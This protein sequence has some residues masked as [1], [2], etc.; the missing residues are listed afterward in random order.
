[1]ICTSP[2]LAAADTVASMFARPS[3]IIWT[4]RSPSPAP[5]QFPP[6]VPLP[7]SIDCWGTKKDVPNEKLRSCRASTI[8]TSI[9]T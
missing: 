2:R 3:F 8:S 9:S 4:T 1:M 6:A 5:I 7:L